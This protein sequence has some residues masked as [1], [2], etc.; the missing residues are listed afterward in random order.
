MTDYKELITQIEA[1]KMPKHIGII[2]DGN[3]RWARRHNTTRLN[4]HKQGANAV[5]EVVEA[6]V[7]IG[8]SYLTIYAFSTE[9]WRRPQVEVH[10]LL[11]LIMDTLLKEIDELSK[12]NIVVRFIGSRKGLEDK[13]YG[14]ITSTCEKSWGNTGLN[15]N[16]AMNYGGRQEIIEMIERLTTDIESGDLDIK[17]L[18]EKIIGK[19]LYT[20]DMPDPDLL[21]RTSGELRLSNFLVWQSAYSELWFTETLWP[22]FN[23]VEFIK[24]ILDYQKR[25]RRFGA[26][27]E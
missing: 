19:Y 1:A 17:N 2:M 9:N 11:R 27:E 25:K 10:G 8:L 15:L 5:R 4:G 20:A 3:G 14:K 18:S 24:A 16:V 26:S 6:S 22:D 7:E 23:R 21:I 12:N 13:Y